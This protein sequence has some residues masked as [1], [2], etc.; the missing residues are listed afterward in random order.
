MILSGVA[1][2]YQ[3]STEGHPSGTQSLQMVTKLNKIQ[4][5]DKRMREGTQLQPSV[6][7]YSATTSACT[8]GWQP[9]R[10]LELLAE[11][12]G[13]VLEPNVIAYNATISA[14][15]KGWQ[16]QRV[17]VL[18]ASESGRTAGLLYN[19]LESENK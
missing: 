14:Y 7:T 18:L 4:H 8:K 13:R 19:R 12:P 2:L 9:E 15:A 1:K 17:L 10:V 5:G 11:M 16:P 3:K 6:I